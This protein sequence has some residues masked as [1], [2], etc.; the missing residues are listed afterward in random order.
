MWTQLERRHDLA[1]LHVQGNCALGTP[2]PWSGAQ[3]KPC[4]RMFQLHSGHTG[5]LVPLLSASSWVLMW[6]LGWRSGFQPC[7]HDR[8]KITS[9]Q[10][11]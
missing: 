1:A 9:D 11:I 6:L 10:K 4:F 7:L 2:R 5:L 3:E 8:W